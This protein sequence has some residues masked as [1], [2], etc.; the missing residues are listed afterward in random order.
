MQ[1]GNRW[2]QHWPPFMQLKFNYS[3]IQ[4]VRFSAMEMCFLQRSNLQC[5]LTTNHIT[6]STASCLGYRFDILFRLRRLYRK[7]ITQCKLKDCVASN[8]TWLSLMYDKH[9]WTS[10]GTLSLSP[11]T[12]QQVLTQKDS[13]YVV[14]FRDCVLFLTRLWIFGRY[15]SIFWPVE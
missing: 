10:E 13:S 2:T 12:A 7:I 4:H 15:E 5:R 1:V 8:E 11:R 3:F 6:T 14:G 9:P